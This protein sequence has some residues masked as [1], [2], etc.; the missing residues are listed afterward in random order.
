MYDQV[1]RGIAESLESLTRDS[2][3]GDSQGAVEAFRVLGFGG[4]TYF[5]IGQSHKGLRPWPLFGR[6]VP[7]E[8]ANHHIQARQMR[9][10]IFMV[11]TVRSGEAFTWTEIEARH[12]SAAVQDFLA[13]CRRFTAELLVCPV[14][15][16]NGDVACVTLWMD[17]A[18]AIGSQERSLAH[19]LALY[20]SLMGQSRLS[21]ARPVLTERKSPSVRELECIYWV[22]QGK[23]DA[24]IGDILGLSASTVHH[25]VE[26]AK[27]RLNARSRIELIRHA[28]D[29]GMVIVPDNV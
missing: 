19:S 2:P 1:A 4:A 22:A 9:Q 26:R 23:T 15:G 14:L 18:R 27:R 5:N 25:H 10:D 6:S 3:F 7:D 29:E 12:P 11:Q 16:V 13:V 21:M 17:E 28:T 20:F 24:E 8:W